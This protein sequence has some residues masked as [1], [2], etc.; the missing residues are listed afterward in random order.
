MES[1]TIGQLAKL[2]GVNVETIRYYQR[3]KLLPQPE[4]PS[5][6]IGRYPL[7]A[8]I[9]LRFIKRSQSLGFSLEDVQALLSLDDGQACSSAKEIG[10]HKLAD[11]RERIQT[12]QALESAL[13]QLV[14]QCAN[15]EREVRC[16]LIEAL[17]RP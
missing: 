1:M 14:S 4:R 12:L 2:A 15:S 11:V 9:R 8:F 5:G 3:R 7:D 16:P 13:Q 17:A 6:G 10:E